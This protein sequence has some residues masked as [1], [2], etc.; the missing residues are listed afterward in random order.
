MSVV[1]D[2]QP[3]EYAGVGG[4]SIWEFSVSGGEISNAGYHLELSIYDSTNTTLQ[5][6]P[7]LYYKDSSDDI[8]A[9]LSGALQSLI[10][11]RNGVNTY[12][13]RLRYQEVW[14]ASS[15]SLT[16]I[17]GIFVA[18][19]GYSSD[20]YVA[21]LIESGSTDILPLSVLRKTYRGYP[22]TFSYMYSDSGDKLLIAESYTKT[23]SFQD[24]AFSIHSGSSYDRT[25]VNQS[26]Q[27]TDSTVKSV[28]NPYFDGSL[29]FW[30][31]VG[32]QN[33]DW[34]YNSGAARVTIT[35]LY[36]LLNSEFTSNIYGWGNQAGVFAQWVWNS[37]EA[38]RVTLIDKPVVQFVE[39]DFEEAGVL[40]DVGE[41]Y[42]SSWSGVIGKIT[43]TIPSGDESDTFSQ[44]IAVSN[45]DKLVIKF[46]TTVVGED[47]NLILR[48]KTDP[49]AVWETIKTYTAAF[50]G[51]ISPE[52]NKITED[53][54][55]VSNDYSDVG[56]K[57]STGSVGSDALTMHNFSCSIQN[58]N[59]PANFYQSM[60]ITSGS[61]INVTAESISNDTTTSSLKVYAVTNGFTTFTEI[62]SFSNAFTGSA[63]VNTDSFSAVA[64]YEGL[65]F[66][67]GGT[68]AD[69]DDYYQLNYFRADITEETT[70]KY[71]QQSISIPSGDVISTD[72]QTISK[73]TSVDKLTVYG[74]KT[75]GTYDPLVIYDN[76]FTTTNTTKT[77]EIIASQ[78]YTAIALRITP[79][80]TGATSDWYDINRFV[81]NITKSASANLLTNSLTDKVT[82]NVTRIGDL[83]NA[84]KVDYDLVQSC[85]N[86][87][88]IK[89]I[90]S[91]GG[92]DQFLFQHTQ[93][94]SYT[95]NRSSKYQRIIVF[96]EDL[97]YE[98][99]EALND[100]FAG[101]DLYEDIN[102]IR[103]RT[104]HMVWKVDKDG[105]ETKV[106]VFETANVAVTKQSIQRFE[107]I[108]E[109]PKEK[110]PK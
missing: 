96:A 88:M 81:V 90:N 58:I 17:A 26:I 82:L 53:V 74:K 30:N 2:T 31:N 14:D 99:Y 75:D 5:I 93:D 62:M 72:I 15:N 68:L 48:G 106:I 45:G 87:V 100:M 77:E 29:D 83:V 16:S 8:L 70:V 22:F 108:V 1:V 57:S 33:I 64:D 63:D 4:R 94:I 7:L 51:G 49:G 55:T 61:L 56:F 46:E 35:A 54:V 6:G 21:Y 109:L 73:A 78:E 79:T 12:S 32:D 95:L 59:P 18:V 91:L 34:I 3:A 38:A 37:A 110:L 43:T 102:G 13:Y 41:V 101:G 36:S 50:K 66:G 23:G 86:S 65:A 24:L 9:D 28:L 60:P 52:P 71:L 84:I 67:V 105:T 98:E 97:T 76:V 19:F 104:N 11:I 25:I 89:W 69:E 27:L 107:A 80:L 39:T 44:S 20:N 40:W 103:Y 85:P 47:V 92:I 42:D 10:D